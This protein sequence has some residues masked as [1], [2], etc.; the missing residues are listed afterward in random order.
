[1]DSKSTRTRAS[2][3]A[4]E[5]PTEHEDPVVSAREA[6]LRYVTD[7]NPGIRRRRRGDVF[8]YLTPDGTLITDEREIERIKHIGI[9][10]AWTDVW[11]SPTARGHIQA[12]GRDAKGRKQYRYHPRWREVRDENKYHRMVDFGESLPGIRERTAHDLALPGL[13][14][15]KVLATIVQLLDTTLVRIGNEEYARENESFGLTTLRED[16]VE[17]EG[18]TVHF[19]FKGKSGK[20]HVIDVKN[21]KLA[22][23]VRRLHELPG[24]E[25]FQYVDAHGTRHAIQSEDV[26]EYLREITGHDFTA[27]DFRTWGGTVIAARELTTLGVFESVTQGKK[28]VTQAIKT[29]AEHLGNTP[30]ICKKS[31]VNPQLLEAY[32]EGTLLRAMLDL[33]RQT[34]PETWQKLHPDEI[35]V[36]AFLKAGEDATAKRAKAG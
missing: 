3:P 8:E 6:G 34:I 20:E 27:K 15:E 13:P 22:S 30:A 29:A 18:A 19:D 2:A 33:A 31:Y 7:A 14:R 35:E 32:L 11:I 21:R 17:V 26:N 5:D 36:L 28:N 1:M 10:P 23:I 16:H 12:T 24:Q 25:V 9:P 4:H